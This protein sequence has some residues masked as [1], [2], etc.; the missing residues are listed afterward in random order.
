MASTDKH[1]NHYS[2]D[3][4]FWP[5]GF[6]SDDTNCNVHTGKNT[7]KIRRLA[8]GQPTGPRVNMSWNP[9]KWAGV[10]IWV[11]EIWD[12][13]V[14]LAFSKTFMLCVSNSLKLHKLKSTKN[15][16]Q[17][18]FLLE[19]LSV[20]FLHL[21]PCDVL[22]WGWHGRLKSSR[23]SRQ[24]SA[25]RWAFCTPSRKETIPSTDT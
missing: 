19:F 3:K 9:G 17:A 24:T 12:G 23:S 8:N 20:C 10:Y 18:S 14:S 7:E 16:F 6:W 2:S 21:L 5:I 4:P 22:M 13:H 15:P 1:A 11:L 25:C